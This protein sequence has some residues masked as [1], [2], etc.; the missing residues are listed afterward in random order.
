M[1]QHIPS[2][3]GLGEY[4]RRYDVAALPERRQRAAFRFLAWMCAVAGLA[5]CAIAASAI[6]LVP[7][8]A[9]E[10]NLAVSGP[11]GVYAASMP[12]EAI[13]G[14]FAYIERLAVR[15]VL[16]RHTLI[17]DRAEMERL[18]GDEGFLRHVEATDELIGD[19]AVNKLRMED[20]AKRLRAG[21]TDEAIL[22]ESRELLSGEVF[23]IDF[24]IVAR[25]GANRVTGIE[26]KR[27]ILEA[28][29]DPALGNTLINPLGFQ[30]TAYSEEPR[31]KR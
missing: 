26:K 24:D 20:M 3:S 4:P 23:E 25:D 30:V 14:D 8:K 17:Q 19:A 27:A 1:L 29:F 22:V 18:W 2:A 11:N 16:A 9:S 5:N 6:A 31:R 15:Y 13:S 21:F 10:P 12:E 28:A 7:L